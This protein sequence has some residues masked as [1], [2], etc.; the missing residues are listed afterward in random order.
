MVRWLQDNA[1]EVSVGLMR[2]A[3]EVE[4]VLVVRHQKQGEEE[5]KTA[6][7]CLLGIGEDH[8]PQLFLPYLPGSHDGSLYIAVDGKEL[9]ITLQEKVALSPLFEAYHFVAAESLHEPSTGEEIPLEEV[10]SRLHR[11]AHSD[12]TSTTR[13]KGDFSD[14]WDSL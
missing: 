6:F 5:H 10:N 3:A 13:D 2:L 8:R 12:E 4:P 1:P 14:L 11:I 9:I 7:G